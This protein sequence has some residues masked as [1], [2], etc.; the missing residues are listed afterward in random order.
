MSNSIRNNK[1]HLRNHFSRL[2][3]AMSVE[4]R[5][6]KSKRIR[7]QLYETPWYRE[8]HSLFSFMN[9]RSE[10]ETYQIIKDA[11]RQGKR[12]M[13]PRIDREKREMHAVEISGPESLKKNKMGI[14]EPLIE[15]PPYEGDIDLLL[16]PGL[17][18]DLRGYRLGYGGGYYDR[19]LAIRQVNRR[20]GLAFEIQITKE[21]PQDNLDQRLNHLISEKRIISFKDM[22]AEKN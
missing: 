2:R 6:E 8:A 16:A 14:W 10:A 13:L 22:E 7:S 11:L 4:E 12:V 9:F 19:F 18:F 21:L 5:Q 15:L 17:A 20:V 3:D 1:I